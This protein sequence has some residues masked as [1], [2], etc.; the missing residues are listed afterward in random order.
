MGRMNLAWHFTGDKLRDGSPIP[1]IGVKLVFA[2]DIKICEQGY[3][4]SKE[5][6]DALKYAPGVM[7]HLVEC[8]GVIQ[9]HEDKGCSSERTI[10]KSID[11][12]YLLR[13]FAADQAL[14]VAYL[15]NMPDIVKEYLETLDESKCM[16]A[17]AAL[18]N[19]FND[20]RDTIDAVGAAWNAIVGA[21]NPY[22][23]ASCAARDA[24]YAA[25]WDKFKDSNWDIIWRSAMASVK[26]D[27]KRRVY[28]A[29]N[30]EMKE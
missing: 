26:N 27:F 16:A 15:W 29:F 7:L 28:T 22:Y 5:P 12:Y 30:M 24:V 9:E 20:S 2:G 13:R 17:E 25:S 14:S 11:A 23:S 1:A 21:D 10:L 19:V 4:W 18:R 6:F 8:G 3:H